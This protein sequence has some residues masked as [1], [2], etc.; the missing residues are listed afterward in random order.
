MSVRGDEVVKKIQCRVIKSVQLD[1][2]GKVRRPAEQSH[3]GR[4]GGYDIS[5]ANGGNSPADTIFGQPY[6]ALIRTIVSG[7]NR[8]KGLFIDYYA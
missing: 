6:L 1:Q 3:N 5:P 7:N 2:T 4:Y 8:A